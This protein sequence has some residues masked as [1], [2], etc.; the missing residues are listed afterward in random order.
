MKPSTNQK[1]PYFTFIIFMILEICVF[2]SHKVVSMHATGDGFTFY[3]TLLCQPWI[4][5]SLVL[6]LIQFFFWTSIL[7]KAE[8]S[9]AYSM[10]SLSYPLTMLAAT[11]IFKEHLSLLV[12]MGGGLITLGVMIVGFEADSH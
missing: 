9:L 11:I 1:F 7:A 3:L 6:A 4:W 2:L 8:L 5:I 10:S 12:W